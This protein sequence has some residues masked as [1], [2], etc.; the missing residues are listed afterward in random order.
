MYSELYS[1]K[2]LCRRFVARQ[3]KRVCGVKRQSTRHASQGRPAGMERS[4]KN[5]FAIHRAELG[6]SMRLVFKCAPEAD[7]QATLKLKVEASARE[8]EHLFGTTLRIATALRFCSNIGRLLFGPASA[9]FLA[10]ALS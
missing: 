1:G 9:W 10:T 6:R 8:H 3:I 7:P 2:I 4:A 5:G